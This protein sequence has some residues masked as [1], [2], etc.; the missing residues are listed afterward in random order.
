MEHMTSTP[1]KGEEK[2]HRK[3]GGGYLFSVRTGM[4]WPPSYHL[5][6]LHYAPA[7]V[8]C[9]QREREIVGQFKPTS[10]ITLQVSCQFLSSWLAKT[11]VTTALSG[12]ILGS[13][14]QLLIDERFALEI[15]N[16]DQPQQEIPASR[17]EVV[18]AEEFGS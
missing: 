1:A 8:N 16:R 15:V 6:P 14:A 4:D 2:E 3:G 9:T 11:Q 17:V 10:G 5:H 13:G 18:V 7:R 12:V